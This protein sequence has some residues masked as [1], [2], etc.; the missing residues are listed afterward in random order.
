MDIRKKLI[1]TVVLMSYLV[2]AM[3]AAV[4]VT[5]LELMATE[6][7]LGQTVLAWVQNSY[8]L[9]WGG[10]MLIGGK[11]SDTFGRRPILCLSLVQFGV[12][13]MV[14]GMAHTAVLLIAARFLQ[15]MGAAVLAPTSLALIIDCFEGQERVK[16][17]AWYGSI[18]GLGTSIGLVVGGLLAGFFSC[19]TV[20]S[21]ICRYSCSCSWWLLRFCRAARM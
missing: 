7:R 3:N 14:A 21:P 10:F 4:I 9:A 18:S 8:V 20:S 6:L 11:L 12:G 15:G 19:V 5:G 17:V 13:S 1:L 2:T 16:A